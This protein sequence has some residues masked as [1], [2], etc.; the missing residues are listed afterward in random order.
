MTIGFGVVDPYFGNCPYMLMAISAQSI[1]GVFASSILFGIVL[2][3]VS[4]GD[5]RAR[6]VAFSDKAIVRACAV[7]GE[8][9]LV[10]RVAEMRSHQLCQAYVHAYAMCDSGDVI[11]D[12][13]S[14]TEGSSV[15]ALPMALQHPD[16]EMM[17]VT[18]CFIVH[19]LDW[20]SPLMPANPAPGSSAV[21]E[22]LTPDLPQLLRALQAQPSIEVPVRGARDSPRIR[23]PEGCD[24]PTSP[25]A[26]VTQLRRR[27]QMVKE[28]MIKCNAEVL[29]L[30]EGVDPTTS[31]TVQ[32]RQSYTVDDICWDATFVPCARRQPSGGIL[33]DFENLHAVRP[34]G[35]LIPASALMRMPTLDYSLPDAFPLNAHPPASLLTRPPDAREERRT[36]DLSSS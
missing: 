31:S 32:A 33:V 13:A 4:R 17:L 6:T 35:H 16:G 3:R 11:G 29:I 34:L 2:T 15:H 9:Y 7:D 36:S 23:S 21:G 5:Q 10:L 1:V 18:P 28:H 24:S 22:Q 20:K 19:R 30:I 25:E 14:A 26:T 8:L 27:L 12:T